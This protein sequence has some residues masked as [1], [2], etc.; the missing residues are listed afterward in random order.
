[1]TRTASRSI[2]PWCMEDSDMATKKSKA[3]KS[4]ATKSKATK[5]KAKNGEMRIRMYRVGFGDFFLV[6]V[7]SADGPQHIVID[8]GVTPGK[9]KKGDIGTIKDAVAHM[10]E[11]TGKKLALIIVTHRHQDHIIGF[12][13]SAE[14]F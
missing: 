1:M 11:E 8:C 3:T 12:S 2:S 5:S 13:R 9:T 7:P 4:K 10:A 6:T 14:I